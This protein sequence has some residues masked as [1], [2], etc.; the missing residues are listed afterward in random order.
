MIR[1]ADLETAVGRTQSNDC[2]MLVPRCAE[3]IVKD[4]WSEGQVRA[5]AAYC[6]SACPFAL[7]GGNVRAAAANAYIGVHQLT[8]GPNRQE[9]G[10]RNLN[11]I[12]TKADPALKRK[13]SIYLDE[14]GVNSDEVFAMMGLATSAGIY[15]VQSA[16][17]LKSGVITKVFSYADE[18]GH[19]VRGPNVKI[20]AGLDKF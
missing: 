12:S 14:M 9:T 8:N 3:K 11:A 6:F 17:G 15:Y 16:E 4:G 20:S 2:P 7:A 18:P 1:A 5:G 13:L 10:R 19:V